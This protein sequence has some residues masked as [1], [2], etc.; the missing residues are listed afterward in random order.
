[1]TSARRSRAS[2]EGPAGAVP[3]SRWSEASRLRRPA[4]CWITC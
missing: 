2:G 1:L 4:G 3:S